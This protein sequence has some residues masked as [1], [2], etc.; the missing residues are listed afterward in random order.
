MFMYVLIDYDYTCKCQQN[1]F[2]VIE[3]YKQIKAGSELQK[4]YFQ[5]CQYYFTNESR[6]VLLRN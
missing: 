2:C 6:K 5:F 3:F 4:V 1:L